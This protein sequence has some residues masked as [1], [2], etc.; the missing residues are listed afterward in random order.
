[1][2]GYVQHNSPFKK[3]ITETREEPGK[4][5]AGKYPGIKSFAGPDGT[6]PINTLERA[7]SA[8]KLAHNS[9]NPEAIR[10][11]VFAKYPELKDN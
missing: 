9:P 3:T 10:K 7:K 8:L 5:N 4:S 2:K 6:Y 11:K 1:M